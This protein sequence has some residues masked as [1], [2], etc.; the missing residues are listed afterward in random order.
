MAEDQAPKITNV[1]VFGN[2]MAMVYDQY[3]KQ[4]PEFQGRAAEVLP[5]IRD[6]GFYDDIKYGGR[7]R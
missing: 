1:Y 7:W 5:K 3:G 2:G 6:A 4:M